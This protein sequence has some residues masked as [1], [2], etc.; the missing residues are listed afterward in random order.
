MAWTGGY[1]WRRADRCGWSRLRRLAAGLIVL[2]GALA[3]GCQTPS[4]STGNDTLPG[5]P[6][7]VQHPMLPGVPI[8]RNARV[9]DEKSHSSA[10]GDGSARMA[11]YEF[12]DVHSREYVYGFYVKLMPTAGFR[13]QQRSDDAGVY[14]LRFQSATEECT[15]LIGARGEKTYIVIKLVP[16]AGTTA[17]GGPAAAA[18]ASP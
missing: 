7:A 9:V 4:S 10:A 2:S 6:D 3:G 17:S 11:H 15:V 1:G 14:T 12:I 18:P 8:P 16:A 13:L 5:A